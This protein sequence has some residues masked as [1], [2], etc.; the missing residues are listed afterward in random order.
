MR[1]RNQ[2]GKCVKQTLP[3]FE[4]V[5]RTYDSLQE[6]AAKMLSGS[7]GYQVIRANVDCCKVDDVAYTTDFVC[8]NG[9]ST[10]A[11]FECVYR[12]HLDKPKT[13]KLL[14]ASQQF[15]EGRGAQW[16]IIIDSEA[17]KGGAD[18]DK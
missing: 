13:V 6:A 1:N 18:N 10:Y 12:K 8:Q 4:G 16:G 5:V 17:R 9:D 2:K 14:N 3:H 7:N 15:W 11:A